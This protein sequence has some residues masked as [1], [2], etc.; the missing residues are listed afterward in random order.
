ML[1]RNL[2]TGS[3]RWRLEQLER[4]TRFMAHSVYTVLKVASQPRQRHN[5]RTDLPPHTHRSTELAPI[6]ELYRPTLVQADNEATI[7]QINI[8][9]N[10]QRIIAIQFVSHQNIRNLRP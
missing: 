3:V 8:E 1:E 6:S 9:Q 4:V 7:R 5:S 2:A 10:I